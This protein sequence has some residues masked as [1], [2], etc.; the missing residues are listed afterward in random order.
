MFVKDLSEVA[1]EERYASQEKDDCWSWMFG[2][3]S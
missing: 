1:L 3:I 2:V